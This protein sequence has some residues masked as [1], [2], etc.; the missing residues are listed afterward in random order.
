MDLD[1]EVPQG[2]ALKIRDSSAN[3][4]LKNIATVQ[5]QDSSGDIEIENARDNVSMRD[6]SGEVNIPRKG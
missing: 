1:I 2:V 4:Y 3:M 5:L 6:S